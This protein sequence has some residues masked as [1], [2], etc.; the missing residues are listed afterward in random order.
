[1]GSV[2]VAYKSRYGSSKEYARL[3]AGKLCCEALDVT[4]VTAEMLEGC[5]TFILCGGIYAGGIGGVSFL[6]KN[7]GKCRDK[8]VVV[9]A[10][11]ASPY[12]EKAVEG[13]R[14]HNLTGELSAF[15]VFYGRGAW[16]EDRM[17]FRD[18]F[19]CGLLKK[20]VA[21]K[22]P[23]ECEPWEAALKEALGKDCSWVD[24]K[25]LEP[26]LTFLREGEGGGA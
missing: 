25:Y 7:I 9:F 1:M 11:G 2:I 8:Q 4:G 13:L 22:D 21:K 5:G 14:R 18:R 20:A 15:P 16:H 24:E 23:A 26:V 17:I 3:L 12:D 10:V 6:K 19:L